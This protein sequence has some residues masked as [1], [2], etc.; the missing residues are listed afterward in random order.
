ME[1]IPHIDVVGDDRSCPNRGGPAPG[2]TLQVIEALADASLFVKDQHIAQVLRR[3]LDD[4][5]LSNGQRYGRHLSMEAR[6]I[7]TMLHALKDIDLG[8]DDAT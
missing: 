5:G 1:I 6:Y 3:A 2:Y 7:P 4:I 8:A